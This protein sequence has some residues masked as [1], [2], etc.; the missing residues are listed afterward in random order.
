MLKKF[1][2]ALV[3]TILLSSV[4]SAIAA[5]YKIDNEGQHAFVQFRI[6]HLGY[7]WV[8]GSFKNFA[9]DFTFDEKNPQNDQ[10]KV[11]INTASIDTNH[12]ERDKHL[13]SA[14][15]FN[16]KKYPEA[17][18]ISTKV[19]QVKGAYNIEGQ[20][21]LNGVTKPIVLNAILMGKGD[22]PWGGYRVGFEATGKIKL[23]DVNF[24]KDLGPKSQQAEL[25]ISLEGV[26]LP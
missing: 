5:N 22:D 2:L 12:A 11:V 10:V 25:I 18:F 17:T 9:G 1:F 24:K 7:S 3:T 15:F 8:Y 23:K 26:K 20:L 6:Q 19:S 4:N 21:T 14:D 13:R 16:V